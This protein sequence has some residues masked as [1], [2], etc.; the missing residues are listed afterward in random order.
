MNCRSLSKQSLFALLQG[1]KVAG[2]QMR[3]GAIFVF[4]MGKQ[5][6]QSFVLPPIRR[7][8]AFSP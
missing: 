2:G 5:H 7:S 4:Y 1:E 6:I 8:G 3:G